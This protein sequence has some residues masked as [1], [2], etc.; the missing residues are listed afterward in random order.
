MYISYK[1]AVGNRKIIKVF[2]FECHGLGNFL[3]MHGWYIQLFI[4]V[5]HQDIFL[6]KKFS[7]KIINQLHTFRNETRTLFLK[8]KCRHHKVKDCKIF[9]EQKYK[10]LKWKD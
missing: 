4:K 2:L 6:V 3:M 8:F 10:K 1:A 9:K 5:Q 7:R